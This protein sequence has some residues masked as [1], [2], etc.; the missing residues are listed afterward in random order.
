M[1]DLIFFVLKFSEIIKAC[2]YDNML[3]KIEIKLYD[4]KSFLQSFI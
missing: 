3:K 1:C 4:L 2:Y